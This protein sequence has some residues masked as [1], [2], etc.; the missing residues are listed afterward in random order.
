MVSLADAFL[1]ECPAT[2]ISHIRGGR[3][4][5]AAN[6]LFEV[7][8]YVTRACNLS[9][10]HCYISA[11]RPLEGE[12]SAEE[13]GAV[14]KQL[15]DLG[16]EVLYI[17]GGEPMMRRDIYDIIFLARKNM[18]GSKISM[19]TNGTLISEEAAAKLR[20]AGLDEVQV[21]IDGPT[22]DVNDAIRTPGSFVKAVLAARR[23]KE[24]G[25]RVTLAYVVL[26]ENAEYIEDMVR[27]AESLGVDGI[28]FSPV[29]GFG[30]ALTGRLSLSRRN[31]ARALKALMSI[32]SRVPITINGFRFYLD[33]IQ[34]A[35]REALA[36]L[37][38]Y[39]KY[40]KT[41]PAGTSRLV[42][43]SNGD[44]YGCELLIPTMKEGNVRERDIKD[45]WL[46]GFKSLRLRDVR[47]VEPC[48][49]CTMADLCQ[50]GC[51]ARALATFKS[52]NAPDPL[53]PLVRR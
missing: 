44:V 18:P 50:G 38:E 42:I 32:K 14:F 11:G 35:Y 7:T 48:S 51:T 24:A 23:L 15:G 34:K 36:D 22:A 17:L 28:N 30:R 8:I 3:G 46:N 20:D 27:L 4:G 6:R 52:I 47:K 33:D 12:L 26:D 1:L 40:Y 31:A 37:G 25:L 19:S 45:I 16:V 13:W 5:L 2:P 10:R 39:A 9:C 49:T 53:C 29:V 41:C 43:D 21:S